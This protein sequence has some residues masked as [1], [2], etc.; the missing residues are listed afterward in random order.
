MPPKWQSTSS[1]SLLLLHKQKPV[2]LEYPW[3]APP[4]IRRGRQILTQIRGYFEYVLFLKIR[5]QVTLSWSD[6]FGSW[7]WIWQVWWRNWMMGR[8]SWNTWRFRLIFLWDFTDFSA[9][10]TAEQNCRSCSEQ[11]KTTKGKTPRGRRSRVKRTDFKGIHFN[12]TC[13]ESVEP[14]AKLRQILWTCCLL[15]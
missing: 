14:F 6:H 7:H 13:F 2:I 4:C 8:T 12:L 3:R 10:W 1:S 5:T 15:L 9:W 11:P